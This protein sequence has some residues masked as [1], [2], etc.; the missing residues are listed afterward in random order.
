MD[1]ESEI[2]EDNEQNQNN[3]MQESHYKTNMSSMLD[4]SK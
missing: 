1:M 3:E 2:T 4:E